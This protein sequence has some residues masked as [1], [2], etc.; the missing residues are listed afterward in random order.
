MPRE[1]SV[2]GVVGRFNSV[3]KTWSKGSK[4]SGKVSKAILRTKNKKP[5]R[6]VG[7]SSVNNP[8]VENAV[9]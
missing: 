8:V 9:G 5:C 3:G 1:C 6:N 2:Y 7:R 4:V